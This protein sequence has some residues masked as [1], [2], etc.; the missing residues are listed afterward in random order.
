M[1]K[2]ILPAAMALVLC[3]C[4]QPGRFS[5]Q[6]AL[7]QSLPVVSSDGNRL[8]LSPGNF[9]TQVN[10]DQNGETVAIATAAGEVTVRAPLVHPDGKGSFHLSPAELGQDFA[11]DGQLTT[12]RRP[13][14]REVD[15]A[16]LHHYEPNYNCFENRADHDCN[17]QPTPVY[18]MQGHHEVGYQD[19]HRLRISILRGRIAG[20][21]AAVIKDDEVIT[22]SHTVG[23]CR[24]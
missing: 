17:W 4:N 19:T 14:D 11:L 9:P 6:L 5:G 12:G 7:Q 16:C 23:S 21:F 13:F 2:F 20:S 24:L 18:G 8:T 22:E 1:K 3:G 10:F 15:R